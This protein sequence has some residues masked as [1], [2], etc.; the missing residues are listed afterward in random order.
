MPSKTVPNNGTLW[1]QYDLR[2]TLTTPLL[3]TIP[4]DPEIYEAWVRTQQAE[5]AAKEGIELPEGEGPMGDEGGFEERGWTT[6]YGDDQGRPVLKAYQFRG[7]LKEAANVIKD[8]VGV[9]NLRHHVENT[10]RIEPRD[11]VLAD[12][13]DGD[14]QRP[15]R[16]MTAQGPRVSLVRSDYVGEGRS[17]ELQMGILKGSK[18][19]EEVIRAILDYGSFK[20]LLQWRTAGFGSFTY[21]L[22]QVSVAG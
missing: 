8:A 2:I 10:V 13:I 21:E 19:T 9:K 18:V 6:F 20:G 15:L 3:G 14:I 16:A 5:K 17:Y 4:K 11:I 7:F 1:D 22:T 12:K